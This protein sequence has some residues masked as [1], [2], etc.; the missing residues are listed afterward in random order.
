MVCTL[1][2]DLPQMHTPGRLR[3][4]HSPRRCGYTHHDAHAA[5]LSASMRRLS[6]RLRPCSGRQAALRSR[7]ASRCVPD[8]P[9]PFVTLARVV[10]SASRPPARRGRVTVPFAGIPTYGWGRDLA[11]RAFPVRRFSPRCPVAGRRARCSGC[12]PRSRRGASV[13]CVVL[14]R[15][16][17]FTTACSLAPRP[18]P[19]ASFFVFSSRTV[20]GRHGLELV[21]TPAFIGR[22]RA[23]GRDRAQSR[24]T[25]DSRAS[26][27]AAA[28]VARASVAVFRVFSRIVRSRSFVP[29]RPGTPRLLVSSLRLQRPAPSRSR[30]RPAQPMSPARFLSCQWLLPSGTASIRPRAHVSSGRFDRPADVSGMFARSVVPD[31]SK[32]RGDLAVRVTGRSTRRHAEWEMGR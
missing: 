2:P 15:A 17:P 5:L 27:F 22:A 11:A 9:A 21:G 26:F 14:A 18:R 29:P 28:A 31:G 4:V 23:T 16:A 24:S 12:S 30:H 3:G 25:R 8:R 32:C 6:K 19:R 10:R 13:W 20:W 7:R 1:T